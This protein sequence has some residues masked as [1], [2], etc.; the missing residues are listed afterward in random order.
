MLKKE[1]D[2]GLNN[3]GKQTVLSEEDT[4]AQL[5]LNILF[6]RPGQMPSMPHIGINIRQYLYSFEEN[7]DVELLKNKISSQ[8]STIIPY[9]DIDN[10]KVFVVDYR[11][12]SIL[13]IIMP[14]FISL[15]ATNLMI[16]MKSSE[17]NG[18]VFN[19]QYENNLL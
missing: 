18:I 5:I 1:L 11:G 13:M 12:E 7:I 9:I 8:C 14:I 2:F 19:Y 15:G 16:G 17:D 3:F 6:M 10:L 4:I